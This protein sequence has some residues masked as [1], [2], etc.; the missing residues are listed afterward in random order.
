MGIGDQAMGISAPHTASIYFVE[1][2]AL[3]VV[4]VENHAVRAPLSAKTS[5]LAKT[6]AGRL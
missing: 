2:D 6:A 3:V 4:S 1:G 5:T